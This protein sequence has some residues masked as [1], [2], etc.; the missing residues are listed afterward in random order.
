[1]KQRRHIL[2]SILAAVGAASSAF[3]QGEL[4]I[5]TWS[6]LEVAV[7]TN[8]PVPAPNGMLEP[9]EAAR[10]TLNVSFTPAVGS[11]A[12]YTPPPGTGVGTVAGL[13]GVFFDI[14]GDATAQGTWSFHQRSSAFS[15]GD[16]GDELPGGTGCTN[17]GAQQF[18]LPGQTANSANPALAIWRIV[19]TPTSYS[20]RNVTWQG[21][22]TISAPSNH[23]FLLLQVGP[24]PDYVGKYVPGQ[25]GSVVVPIVPAPGVGA[26]VLGGALA[27]TRRRRAR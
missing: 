27:A 12:T 5:H 16:P 2:T 13:G 17:A 22:P 3:A 11:T 14:V 26:V 8:S 19:W 15:L 24:T 21:R 7:G 10:L 4:A 9:G 18:L 6:F 1:M 23:S 20:T 25:F